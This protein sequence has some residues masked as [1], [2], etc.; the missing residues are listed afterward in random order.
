[1]TQEYSGY[2]WFADNPETTVTG[3]LS[4]SKSEGVEL[5]TI[6]SLLSQN[7]LSNQPSDSFSQKLLLGQSIDQKCITLV[8]TICTNRSGN[9]TELS[10]STHIANVAIIG[11]RHFPSKA[12]ILFSSAE[13]KLS[14]LN[15]WLCKSGFTVQEEGNSQ[16]HLTRFSLKYEYP[17]VIEFSIDSIKAK[18]KTSYIFGKSSKH[19]NWHLNHKSL[20]KLI[21]D[22]PQPY[23]WYSRNFESL[24]KF[25]IVMTGFPVSISDVVGYG[26]EFFIDRRRNIKIRERFQIYQKTPSSFLDT[27]DKRSS[28]LL[29]NLS[30]LGVDLKSVLSTWFEK[31]E[32]LDPAVILYTATSSIDLGYVEFRLLNYAQGLEALHRRVFGG[33]YMTDD[34]YRVVLFC[35][36][37]R[38]KRQVRV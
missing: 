23:E 10:H 28:S 16:G 3:N 22:E 13:F 14:L 5:K 11:K 27:E 20:F 38:K 36:G 33:K 32:I 25:L 6:G 17:E 12:E 7:T 26:D 19:L 31:S 24:R 21:P 8:G 4:L 29:I 1:V 34:K 15:E 37:L 9:S 18:F 35:T 2:W 30:R